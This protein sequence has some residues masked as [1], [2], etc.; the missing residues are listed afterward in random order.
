M[1]FN[2]TLDNALPTF[3][4]DSDAQFYGAGSMPTPESVVFNPNFVPNSSIMADLTSWG[5]FDSLVTAGIGLFD[6]AGMQGDGGFGFGFG[7]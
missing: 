5:Q 4:T 6:S 3:S 7:L 2:P 1:P